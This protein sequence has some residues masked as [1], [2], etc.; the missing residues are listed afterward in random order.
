MGCVAWTPET[1]NFLKLT[2][3]IWVAMCIGVSFTFGIFTNRM[4]SQFN[5]TQPDLTTISTIGYVFG[6]FNFPA[7]VVWDRFGPRA[8]LLCAWLMILLGLGGF[9]LTFSGHI[10]GSVPSFSFYTVMIAWSSGW[11]DTGSL[12]TNMFNF[13]HNN[14]DV[15]VLQKTFM[16]LGG[17]MFASFYAGWF[18]EQIT[19]FSLFV[20]GYVCV[21]VGIGAY[22]V[23]LPDY[24]IKR[25]AKK[26]EDI[27]PVLKSDDTEMRGEQTAQRLQQEE[28]TGDPEDQVID[29]IL[30]YPA[31]RQRMNTGL[32]LLGV[33]LVYLTTISCL[34]AF[35]ELSASVRAG[36][37]AVTLLLALSFVSL[38][39]RRVRAEHGGE[40]SGLS[41][42]EADPT[43]TGLAEVQYFTK[44]TE[45][46]KKLDIWLLW[47][48]SFCLLG[49][50]V[51]VIVNAAQIYRSIN[52]NEFNTDTNSLNVAFIG[53]GSAG[54]RIAVGL[55]EQKV[56][57]KRHL[58]ITMVFPI[59]HVFAALGLL[60]ML[61]LPATALFVP[62]FLFN[63]G[64]G[65]GWATTVLAVR[66]M[67]R[68]DVAKHYGFTF[69]AG[70]LAVVVLNRFTFGQLFGM[71]AEAQHLSPH[72]SGVVCVRTALLIM[73]GLNVSAIGAALLLHLRWRRYLQQSVH[74]VE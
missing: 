13:P 60:L 49:S 59:S 1:W 7:G 32:A 33:M 41:D 61:P 8:V 63:W 31:N 45:S 39:L 11:M 53:L 56:L 29:T 70:M 44:F 23:T 66:R 64:L 40:S 68:Y 52:G 43:P 35:V 15:V 72:C 37:A 22:V 2:C 71:E 16:G 47:W 34:L 51:T 9:A 5:L 69:T 27:P 19:E 10:P 4:K 62:F 50:G 26:K 3:G 74:C 25:R 57:K 30:L 48:C 20:A 36:L 67:W 28:A 6:M 46:L 24:L 12:M 38:P 17:T 58:P 65:W 55:L 21:L 73:T 54:G 14:G 42:I 18:K